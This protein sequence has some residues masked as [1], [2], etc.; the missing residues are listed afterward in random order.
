MSSE[1]YIHLIIGS[2]ASLIKGANIKCYEP[3]TNKTIMMGLLFFL[4]ERKQ[5]FWLFVWLRFFF[6]LF[7]A[8][9]FGS[10][11]E[12]QSQ[13]DVDEKRR[14]WNKLKSGSA[15]EFHPLLLLEKFYS[16]ESPLGLNPPTWKD[17]IR[18]WRKRIKRLF[19]NLKPNISVEDTFKSLL[20][21]FIHWRRANLFF[22][23]EVRLWVNLTKMPHHISFPWQ[24]WHFTSNKKKL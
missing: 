23:I 19:K 2:N 9:C 3:F 14:V 11:L 21:S 4:C 7:S 10:V 6:F 22:L 24:L 20:S 18:L 5:E 12:F 13:S 8:T 1:S 16:S 15:L 17:S